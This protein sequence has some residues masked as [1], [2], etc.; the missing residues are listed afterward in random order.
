MGLAPRGFP[1]VRLPE[2]LVLCL[3][4]MEG[5]RRFPRRGLS[6]REVC[7]G[8][9]GLDE[10]PQKGTSAL[11]SR[12]AKTQYFCSFGCTTESSAVPGGCSP[13]VAGGL[14]PTRSQMGVLIT[15][16]PR[17]G[18]QASSVQRLNWPTR[19]EHAKSWPAGHW[20]EGAEHDSW[21]GGCLLIG[22]IGERQEC[23][24]GTG[25]T[26]AGSLARGRGACSGGK[27]PR[28]GLGVDI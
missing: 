23:T 9:W 10:P 19:T 28:A 13:W 7:R 11:S 20:G 16:H 12:R 18:P 25:E 1:T 24:L 2:R 3:T 22:K 4:H 6:A 14:N 5:G 8:P 21:G 27:N 15:C 17:L 26:E